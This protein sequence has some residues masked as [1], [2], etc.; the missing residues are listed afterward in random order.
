MIKVREFIYK[1]WD[2]YTSIHVAIYD[3]ETF[4]EEEIDKYVKYYIQGIIEKKDGIVFMLRK[5]W[6][7]FERLHTKGGLNGRKNYSA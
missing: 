5:D 7:K 3:S 4:T 2:K 6:Y 1:R